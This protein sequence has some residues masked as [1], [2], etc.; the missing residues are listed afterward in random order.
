MAS[1]S[2]VSLLNAANPASTGAG[3]ALTTGTATLTPCQ[4]AGVA[5]D[6]A[7]VNAAGQ[8]LGWYPGLII[9]VTAQGILTT[10]GTST[11]ATIFITANKGNLGSTYTTLATPSGITTGTTVLSGINWCL[12]AVIRCTAVAATGNT[13]SCQGKLQL[14]NEL[15]ALPSNPVAL[16]ASPPPGFYLPLPNS[17]GETASAVDTTQVTGINIRGTLAAANSTIQVT[18]WLAEALT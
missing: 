6:V 8:P 10:T 9:R 1:Q 18:S 11:T 14:G 17:G 3:T 5:V 12:E 4:A 7:V 13:V 16:S 15:A 2:W